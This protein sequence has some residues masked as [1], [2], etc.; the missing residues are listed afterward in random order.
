MNGVPVSFSVELATEADFE[1]V[2]ALGGSNN[3][4]NE[5]LNILNQVEGLYQSELGL[6]FEVVF[7]H[8]WNTASDPYI[9]TAPSAMLQ[10]F[11]GIGTAT[12]AT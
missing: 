2:I 12:S 9:S 11:T 8:T 1:Y 7:Q 4:N 10:E 6:T 5:I 3:A